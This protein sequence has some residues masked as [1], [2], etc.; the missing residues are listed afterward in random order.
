MIGTYRT[1]GYG[2]YCPVSGVMAGIRQL[3]RTTKIK[4]NLFSRVLST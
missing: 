1:P 2:R 4:S 3:Y